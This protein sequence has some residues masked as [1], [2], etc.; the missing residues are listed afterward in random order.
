MSKLQYKL[1]SMVMGV[2]LV[3]SMLFVSREAAKS[4]NGSRILVGEEKKMCGN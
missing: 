2:L 4:V 3:V 1:L